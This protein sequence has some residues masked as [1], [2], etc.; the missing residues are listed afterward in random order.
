[1]ISAVPFWSI[2]RGCILVNCFWVDVAVFVLSDH[3]FLVRWAFGK[4]NCI[5][6]C[7]S[8]ALLIDFWDGVFQVYFDISL[9]CN[10]KY[11]DHIA[12]DCF[13]FRVLTG[14]LESLS[15]M[16]PRA[17]FTDIED[18]DET[19]RFRLECAMPQKRMQSISAC[20]DSQWVRAPSWVG[21]QAGSGTPTSIKPR[22]SALGKYVKNAE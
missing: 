20:R 17:S 12:I 13:S 19:L 14:G 4:S 15:S 6:L 9:Q 16:L 1:M 10:L 2:Q 22:E 11:P 18:D 5:C 21:F 3:C 8:Q 7:F